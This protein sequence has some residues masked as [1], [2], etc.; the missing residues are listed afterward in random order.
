MDGAE[1]RRNGRTVGEILHLLTDVGDWVRATYAA[2][3]P[4]YKL[5]L[6]MSGYASSNE[7]QKIA[8]SRFVT[9]QFSPDMSLRTVLALS[10]DWHLAVA[11]DTDTTNGTGI[12]PPPWCEAG[13]LAGYEFRPITNGADL[14]LE[15]REMHHCVSTYADR[16]LA[17][18]CY[19][20]SVTKDDEKVATMELFYSQGKPQLG[21]I[22]GKC[23]SAA[24]AKVV[25]AARRWL[26]GQ[27][28]IRLPQPRQTPTWIGLDDE[29]PF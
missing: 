25:N 12:F 22:R 28:A 10:E 20:Y 16:V 8:G 5:A 23:N 15:G 27:T 14:Y 24:P 13:K 3:I 1:R 18:G 2:G 9:R 7:I 6:V 19:V 4:Q 21:Q 17:G 11:N 26:R 29:I